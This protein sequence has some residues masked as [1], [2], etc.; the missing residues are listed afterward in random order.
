MWG[1]NKADREFS[2]IILKLAK[3]HM[4]LCISPGSLEE[5]N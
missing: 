2:F 3:K 4:F 5:Q 1:I